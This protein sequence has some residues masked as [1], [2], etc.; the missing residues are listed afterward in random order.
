MYVDIDHCIPILC[1]MFVIHRVCLRIWYLLVSLFVHVNECVTDRG[2]YVF[3]YTQAGVCTWC[4]NV[5]HY[6][7]I[8]LSIYI[9]IIYM[10]VWVSR[11]MGCILGELLLQRPLMP[12]RTEAQQVD[13]IFK[14]CRCYYYYDNDD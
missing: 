4:W 8:Y 13:K 7:S 9:Y 14:V 10:R 11:A 5:W 3:I 1:V 2:A 6:I 12:G